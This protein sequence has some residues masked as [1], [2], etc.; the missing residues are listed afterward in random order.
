M[1]SHMFVVYADTLRIFLNDVNA[2]DLMK[3]LNDFFES[4]V[5]ILEY[6]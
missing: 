5:N 3:R 2:K 1:T 6:E 4:E